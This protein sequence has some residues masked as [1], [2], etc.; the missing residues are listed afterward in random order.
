M[1]VAAVI[2]GLV[3]AFFVF[4]TA[5]LLV[6]TQGLQHTRVGGQGAYIGAVVFPILALGAGLLAIRLWRRGAS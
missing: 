2:V 4:Y 6:V 3:S 5:R 1:R